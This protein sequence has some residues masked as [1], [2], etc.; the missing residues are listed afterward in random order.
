MPT[1]PN[2]FVWY[3]L[4]TTDADAAKAF[5]RAVV[6]WDAQEWGGGREMRYI[7]MSAG[8]KMVAGLMPLPAEVSAA[9]GRP[10]WLG[11]VG[12]N[13]V[14]AATQRVSQAGGA[15]YRAPAD[16]P[17]VG[18]FSVVADPQGAVFMLFTPLGADDSPAAAG[19]A[20]HVGWR[21]LYASDWPRAFDF[22]S[23]QFGWTKADAVDM[24]PM[25]IYQ[26]FA[27]GGEPIGGM[28]NKPDGVPS[29]A[30][31]FYFNVPEIDAAVARV[32]DNGGGILTG[33]LQVPG[34]SWIVQ[35]MDP[36]GAMFALVACTR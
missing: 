35:C 9:G 13:D 20:G 12:T 24:G 27:A 16:I 18:R 22:Y 19:T 17:D 29:P 30:W 2:A 34:G 25:G 4:M 32:T 15:V 7:I 11:Y 14:D 21:E 10:G 6:G 36:Q 31:L 26:L 1:S 23:A 5:Y 8:E 3:E 33:P 28:M